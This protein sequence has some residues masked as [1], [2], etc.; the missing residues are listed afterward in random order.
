M[1]NNFVKVACGAP[2]VHLADPIRNAD[3]LIRL[4]K[5][6]DGL[7]IALIVFPELCLTGSTCGDLFR[8]EKLISTAKNQLNRYLQETQNC[9]ITS[10]IGLP[11]FDNG[12]LINCAAV[13]RSGK[14]LGL[15]PKN[16]LTASEMRWFSPAKKSER[17][18]YVEIFGEEIS[19]NPLQIFD[20][21]NCNALRFGIKISGDGCNGLGNSD[22]LIK[23]G[24]NILCAPAASAEFAGRD[25]KRRQNLLQN[26]SKNGICT[27]YASSGE[28]ES[29]TDYV[30]GAHR[31]ICGAEQVLA[32][33]LPFD[34][35]KQILFTEINT[36]NCRANSNQTGE[37]A[38]EASQNEADPHPF[39]PANPIDLAEHCRSVLNIQAYGLKQRIVKAYAKKAVIGISGGLD[40]TL[41]ILV[42]VR[43]MDLLNR[44][45]TDILAVTM[46]CFGT[47]SRTKS[48]ATILCEELGVD[49]RC[50]TIGDAVNQHFK[51]IGHDPDVRDITYENSQA[52]ERT[53]VLMDLANECGGM[54]IGTGDLSE[55]AL[56]WAT[57]NGDHMSMYGVNANL[58]K[59]LIR[60]V[61]AY[62]ADQA[63]LQGQEKLAVSLRDILDTPVSP[64]LLPAD[65]KG[66]IAQ[67]T[68]DLVGPYEL[69][70][71]YL[72]HLLS[73]GYSPE[74][75]YR[76]A[77][78]A[79]KDTYSDQVLLKWLEV[80][81]RRFF[82]QQ[83]KRSC[84]PDGPA[85]F[86][87]S[88]SPRGGL[89]MPSDASSAIWLEEVRE[90]MNHI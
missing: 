65:G 18:A 35:E 43:A 17:A 19:I 86:P 29:T 15:I 14:I 36:E 38:A 76:L 41:A 4:T 85:V 44:P 55:L 77:K 53:Q 16:N 80:F 26:C 89:S 75:L 58:P 37:T 70:D 52:R 71:F 8:N 30:Y 5:E 87:I 72:Y 45:R 51:D 33:T 34:F 56:G 69:H 48:N 25:A 46:P 83:F 67:K 22:E 90:L 7:A 13:C 50:V 68:E 27:L 62:C 59:T 81:L 28:G 6:A 1:K 21:P 84:L 10:V 66:Q 82:N 60:H 57:Y 12:T 74:K 79:F 2:S 63:D 88:L 20:L 61:V 11:L 64:E 31:I 9:T 39:F 54:V 73:N 47:T 40:S 32:E 23:A 3:E 78:K 24:A 49:F 42:A